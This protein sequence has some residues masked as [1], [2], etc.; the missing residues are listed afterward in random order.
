[1]RPLKL[2][3]SAFG[4]Y[5]GTEELK[6]EDLGTGGI[7]LITG[8]TG[9]GKT[10]IFDAITYALYGAPSGTV[11]DSSMLRSKYAQA[12][13]PTEVELVFDYAGK[14]YTVKRSPEFMRP[15]AR[16]EGL[17]KQAA[18]AELRCPDGRIVTKTDE[19]NSAISEIMG[20]DRSQ[21]MQI[22]MIAQGDFLKLL[23]ATTEDRKTIFRRI[24]RTYPYQTLQDELLR[25][26][27]NLGDQCATA[28]NSLKQY[29]DGIVADENDVLSIDVEKAK[30]GL[31]PVD[32]IIA[33]LGKLI[34]QD[35]QT[36][37]ERKAE[38]DAI[39]QQL[40]TVTANL[41]KIDARK[42][43]EKAIEEKEKA[44]AKEEPCCALL[45]ARRDELDGKKGEME[46]RS[47]EKAEILAELPRY[48]ALSALQTDIEKLERE[49]ETLIRELEKNAG[50]IEKGQTYLDSLRKELAGLDTAGEAR[51]RLSTEK[52]KAEE[53]RKRFADLSEAL[54]GLEKKKQC[55]N[56]L[57]G[58]YDRAYKAYETA[59]A[60]YKAKNSA[61]LK[62]QAGIL[63]L[64][65]ESGK[66]CPVCGSTEHPAPARKSENAPTEE[67]LKTAEARSDAAQKECDEK[68]TGYIAAK[69]DREAAERH[70]Q[71]Q[72]AELLPGAETEAAADLTGS[73]LTELDSRIKDLGAEIRKEDER[74]ERRNT[75][76]RD[77]PKY[78]SALDELK[79]K[80]DNI[81]REIAAKE[82]ALDSQIKHREA[83]RAALRFES[84][85]A[86]QARISAIEAEVNTFNAA[87]K[88]A[89]DELKTSE[90]MIRELGAS[91]MIL[92]GQLSEE[93]AL[94]EK[95]ET[96]KK[97]VLTAKGEEISEKRKTLYARISANE[98]TLDNIKVKTGDL[99]ALESR[100]IWLRSLSNTAN[101]SISGKEKIMLETYIQTTYFDRIIARAN[102][103]FMV[104][105]GGQYELK[106]R[107]DAEN[108]R[109][110]SGLDLDVMDHYN[111]SVR[112]VRTLSGG[113]S[114]KA[115]L[116]LALGLSDEIQASAGGVQLDS[117]F[118]DEGFG[119]LDD[120][121][122]DQAMK[123]LS[124]LADGN[125]LV[126]IIS[127]VA[128]L[129]NR[130]DRQIVVTKEKE[131]GSRASIIV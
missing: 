42:K 120:E 12:E 46:Q 48:D 47:A 91:I 4:P 86:A 33:L 52:E 19:V 18:V 56:K 36:D 112:S 29:I 21:F 115:S 58:E 121:S 92:K 108:L 37:D 125:R 59:N 38:A 51:Q 81:G 69:T 5:A 103:R 83:D 61:F 67:E 107:E 74:V 114:F 6:L 84:R 7:Y 62:E 55:V 1:M 17:T 118:V 34:G 73:R 43:T 10:T 111:G 82:A 3:M 24:F 127:H 85:A 45:R 40:Q 49:H 28:K 101:G 72:L 13:T 63:A 71:D 22:A 11:R 25:Q 105:S 126:G 54:K 110:K 94:D 31:L 26:A 124:G 95:T 102:T 77:I 60:G 75:L 20:I 116:S 32:E 30:E 87:L 97:N 113:E 123:A 50:R 119:S 104:M 23:L 44:K 96:E 99:A 90:N 98:R 2:K 15:K 65:L 41:A 79:Q 39:E 78:E 80:G 117:M 16:G 106:R 76:N 57:L 100:Y 64:T 88:K 68:R 122:L 70:I 35:R 8:D 130:I 14:T 93:Q 66:A 53:R 89:D 9:A 27:K 128:E 109:S 131:G 129:K